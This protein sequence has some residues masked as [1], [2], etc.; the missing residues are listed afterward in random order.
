MPEATLAATAATQPLW[1]DAEERARHV[2]SPLVQPQ[3]IIVCHLIIVRSFQAFSLL[4][5]ALPDPLSK[6]DARWDPGAERPEMG[7]S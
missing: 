1:L 7:Q 3:I 2:N 4:D 5:L 6:A